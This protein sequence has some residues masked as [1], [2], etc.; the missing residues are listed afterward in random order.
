MFRKVN[1]V[2]KINNEKVNDGGVFRYKLLS[3][4]FA[5]REPLKRSIQYIR[6]L[7]KYSTK[8]INESVKLN[9]SETMTILQYVAKYRHKI[10]YWRELFM[11]LVDNGININAIDDY[12]K[13]CTILTYVSDDLEM[14]HYVLTHKSFIPNVTNLTRVMKN[15]KLENTSHLELYK[16][17]YDLGGSPDYTELIKSSDGLLDDLLR[18]NLIVDYLGQ[19]IDFSILIQFTNKYLKY[20]K[21]DDYYIFINKLLEKYPNIDMNVTNN[22]NRNLM[23]H[24]NLRTIRDRQYLNETDEYKQKR[25]EI[26]TKLVTF[27]IAK[28]VDPNLIDNNGYT[29]LDYY[30]LAKYINNVAFDKDLYSLLIKNGCKLSGTEEDVKAQFAQRFTKSEMNDLVDMII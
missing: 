1:S 19:D 29:F 11:Y 6:D 7:N 23:F 8:N 30:F 4:F 25:L 9:S 27:L 21:F 28:D 13:K 17:M 5:D 22:Y 14:C 20:N 3:D 18:V 2:N 26:C 15:F 10:D 24:L 12:Y 16:I